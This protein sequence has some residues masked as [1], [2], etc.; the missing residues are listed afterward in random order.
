MLLF[1]ATASHFTASHLLHTSH[2][3]ICK[4]GTT[5]NLNLN[6]SIGH[7][8]K[9]FKV[10][11]TLIKHTRTE[12]HESKCSIGPGQENSCYQINTQLVAKQQQNTL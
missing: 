3:S 1:T 12:T 11:T 10:E 2:L 4:R 7:M 9:Q 8:Q 5:T 6:C